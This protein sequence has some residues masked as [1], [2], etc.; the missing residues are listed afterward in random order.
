MP[1]PIQLLQHEL[2]L[3]TAQA[4]AFYRT[5]NRLF[6]KVTSIVTSIIALNTTADLPEMTMMTMLMF[7]IIIGS[8]VGRIVMMTD[9]EHD[10][11]CER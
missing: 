4:T 9:T 7:I 2:Q 1:M 6:G 10:G 3:F 5:G 11:G 8:A